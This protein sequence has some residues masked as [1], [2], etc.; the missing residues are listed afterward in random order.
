MRRN[1]HDVLKSGKIDLRREYLRLFGLLYEIK[2]EYRSEYLTL[3]QIIEKEFDELDENLIGRCLSLEEFNNCYGYYF[4]SRPKNFSI[5]TLIDLAEYMENFLNALVARWGGINVLDYGR[6]YRHIRSCMEDVG[7]KRVER[8]GIIIYVEKNAAAE[9][10]AEIVESKLSYSVLEYNHYRLK[11]N[12][13]RKKDILKNMADDIEPYRKDLK[14][15]NKD[16]ESN[17]FQLF[18]KFIR[19]NNMDNAYIS[20]MNNEEIEMVYDE[21]YQMWLLAKME[22][23]YQKKSGW[24]KKLLGSINS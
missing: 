13:E 4:S 22:L 3:E 11:G 6:L 1:I 5:E 15:L 17:L 24:I 9:S 7:Y 21:I 18:N 23:Q 19:H 2:Y 14:S 8:D 10:V 16:L 12:L 20:D